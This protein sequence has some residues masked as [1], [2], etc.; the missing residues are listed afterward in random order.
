LNQ[1]VIVLYC[2]KCTKI[3]VGACPQVSMLHIYK[4][5]LQP[6]EFVIF[7][8]IV[9]RVCKHFVQLTFTELLVN[10]FVMPTKIMTLGTP[11][12]LIGCNAFKNRNILI[13]THVHCGNVIMFDN[14]SIV[15]I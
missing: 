1:I 12:K 14:V 7:I 2:D 3:H 8:S 10:C 13:C 9:T 15:C 6:L 4:D 11:F 5:P